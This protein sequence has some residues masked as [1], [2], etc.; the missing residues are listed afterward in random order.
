[1]KESDDIL[2]DV[3]HAGKSLNLISTSMQGFFAAYCKNRYF[4]T[5]WS[6]PRKR[7]VRAIRKVIIQNYIKSVTTRLAS[8]QV[9]PPAILPLTTEK[10]KVLGKKKM[11]FCDEHI[12]LS[13][14]GN[15]TVGRHSAIPLHLQRPQQTGKTN[16]MALAFRNVGRIIGGSAS[17]PGTEFDDIPQ[18]QDDP[19]PLHPAPPS[20]SGSSS[21]MTQSEYYQKLGTSRLGLAL[22][23]LGSDTFRLWE[24]LT[25]GT[26]PVV[27]K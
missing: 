11:S 22:S 9:T 19:P 25:M 7:W 15:K 26:V 21:R 13:S 5:L 23:G 17:A 12:G 14:A 6:V 16:F 10:I 20:N 18:I 4:N 8:P 2:G 27:E 1:M 24:A 3:S